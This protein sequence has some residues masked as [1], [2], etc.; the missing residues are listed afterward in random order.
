[1]NKNCNMCENK[2]L[3]IPDHE[4]YTVVEERNAYYSL[5][6][7]IIVLFKHEDKLKKHHRPYLHVRAELD[8]MCDKAL[9][10]IEEMG[11]QRKDLE[12]RATDAACEDCICEYTEQSESTEKADNED[13]EFWRMLNDLCELIEYI[14]IQKGFMKLLKA[15]INVDNQLLE[16]EDMVHTKTSMMSDRWYL[17]MWEHTDHESE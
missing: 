8:K 3:L 6:S 4:L 14:E 12:L 7:N 5:L 11:T 17:S 10:C 9:K 1:M 16:F 13:S 2:K 15:G